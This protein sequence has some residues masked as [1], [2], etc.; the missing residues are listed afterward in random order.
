MALEAVPEFVERIDVIELEP[1]VMAAN[2][3][4]AKERY[5]DPLSDP[6]VHVHLNDAR[7]ALSLANTRFD[8][9]VSQPS[10]PW[11]GGAAHLYTHEF[12]TLVKSRLSADGVFLQWIGLPFVDEELFRS[13]LA[14]LADVFPYVQAYA[15]PP[16]GS[17]L[18][19]ASNAPFDMRASTARALAAAPERFAEIGVR[20]PE[21]VT[22]SLLLDEEA[23]RE[24]SRGAPLNRDGH[25]RLASRSARLGDAALRAR[26]DDFI[27]PVDPLVR[28]LPENTDVFRLL[29][30]VRTSRAR[31][32]AAALPDPADRAV[33]EALADIED[34]KRVGPSQRIQATLAQNP[35]HVEARAAMLRLSAGAIADGA[36]PETFVAAPLSDAERAV[37]AGWLARGDGS[38]G[39]ALRAL[40][41]QLAAIAPTHPLGADAIRL[42][43][44]GRIASGDAALAE[45]ATAL[46]EASLSDRPEPSSIL[47]RAEASAAAGDP[48]AA[49]ETLGDLVDHLDPKQPSAYALA[50]RARELARSMPDDGDLRILRQATLQRLG[51]RGAG[52]G[53]APAMGAPPMGEPR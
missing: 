45:E 10:H 48:V 53:A 23:V 16:D 13:L 52:R 17:A 26:I 38:R 33:G 46:A 3:L 51:V 21:I 36:N 14:T 35:D 40:E 42:R 43:V 15:P 18:F 25:N 27:A 30:Y 47:L 9:I 6:R 50:N 2:R 11:A 8:V 44:Q 29:R 7:N 37:A 49:L 4:V 1:E 12:F 31:R 39:E 5:R 34:G 19:I 20:T 41:P 24:V 28:A 22:A 32:I